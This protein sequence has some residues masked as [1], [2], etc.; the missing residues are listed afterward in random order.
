MPIPTASAPDDPAPLPPMQDMLDDLG[1]ITVPKSSD[2]LA[3]RLQLQILK[4]RKST[5]LNS[6][7]G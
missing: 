4:D 5:R 6:S 1:E 3:G 7:H 2:V